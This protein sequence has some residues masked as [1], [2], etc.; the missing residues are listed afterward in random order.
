MILFDFLKYVHQLFCNRKQKIIQ[1][2]ILFSISFLII[3]RDIKYIYVKFIILMKILHKYFII[4][5]VDGISYS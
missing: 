4:K 5:N 2:F 1:A 3:S